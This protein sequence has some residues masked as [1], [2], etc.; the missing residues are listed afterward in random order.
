MLRWSFV[1]LVLSLVAAFLG[2]GGVAS[3]A[4][5]AAKILFFIFIIG[6]VVT[7]V[8]GL[9]SGRNSKSLV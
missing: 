9:M 6:W 5:E 8:F 7:L 2:F 4:A 1:F 3:G